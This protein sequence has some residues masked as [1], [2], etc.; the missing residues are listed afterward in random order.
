MRKESKK[1]GEDVRTQTEIEET[2]RVVI[3]GFSNCRKCVEIREQIGDRM[4]MS[5]VGK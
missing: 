4:H 5:T 3:K 2:I 1:I